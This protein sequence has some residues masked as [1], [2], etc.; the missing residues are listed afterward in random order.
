M[1]PF[2]VTTENPRRNYPM[3]N[4]P[5]TPTQGSKSSGNSATEECGR[6]ELDEDSV[7]ELIE[8]F[9]LLDKW[10]REA[11]AKKNE[12]E[13]GASC[14]ETVGSAPFRKFS[15]LLLF[16]TGYKSV[17]LIRSAWKRSVLIV[18]PLQFHDSKG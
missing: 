18:R 12:I 2:F 17:D 3:P 7:R 1:I 5:I 8:F 4:P 11:R 14:D 16:S 9:T 10:D 13:N 6:R 15:T